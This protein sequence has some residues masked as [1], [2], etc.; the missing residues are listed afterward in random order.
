MLQKKSGL[1]ITAIALSA[2]AVL[3]VVKL[4]SKTNM[5]EKRN[6]VAIPDQAAQPQEVSQKK[7]NNGDMAKL[8]LMQTEIATLTDA[9]I[10]KEIET[11]KIKAQQ[12]GLLRNTENVDINEHPEA[13][14]LLMRMALLRIEK[15]KRDKKIAAEEKKN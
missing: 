14:E 9:D 1:V 6:A 7:A 13:K 8:N 10:A 15:A 3:L 12:S 5:Q 2:F 4:S 11:I